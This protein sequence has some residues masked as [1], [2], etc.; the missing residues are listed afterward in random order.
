ML[1]VQA[2]GKS[3]YIMGTL[4]GER[5]RI[6]TGLPLR[7]RKQAEIIKIKT[8]DA[9]VNGKVLPGRHKTFGD[10]IESYEASLAQSKGSIPLT[11]RR[12]ISM[13]KSMLGKQ[14]LDKITTHY[15]TREVVASWDNVQD[16]SRSRYITILNA[17][18][19][20]GNSEYGGKVK[21]YPNKKVDDTRSIH[22]TQQEAKNFLRFIKP[23][24]Y[25]MDFMY[26]IFLGVRLGELTKMEID[27]DRVFVY[28]PN[29]NSK[30]VDRTLPIPNLLKE[31]IKDN[32]FNPLSN[33]KDAGEASFKL[34]QFL[35]VS[36]LQIGIVKHMRVHDLRHT[37]AYLMA[38]RGVDLAELQFLLGHKD[39]RMTMKYRG[40]IPSKAEATASNLLGGCL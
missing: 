22:F 2:R 27:G 3:L 35:R 33:F 37:F 32:G 39:I 24:V 18:I 13:L 17:V 11:E 23:S 30:T 4:L 5:V 10:Y 31:A 7:Q 28:D 25:Y 40:Y 15:L 26:L 20:H 19:N 1:R 29:G 21:T 38:Q 8:E 6:S 16:N 14:K 36:C 34:N 12:I 9:I